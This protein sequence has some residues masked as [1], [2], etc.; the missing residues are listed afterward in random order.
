M[1]KPKSAQKKTQTPSVRSLRVPGEQ[2]TEQRQQS[3]P[4]PSSLDKR[5][6][7]RFFTNLLRV[8]ALFAVIGITLFVF[9][10]RDRVEQF[11]VLGYPGIF[12]I[13]LLANA[14]VLLPAPGVAVIYAM[15]AI[16][17]PFGVGL[18][19]GT[20]GALGELSGYLAGFS[21]QAVVERTDIYNRVRPWVE[22]YGG[23]A[24]LVLSAIPNPFFDIAG[25]AAG[26]AKMPVRTFLLFT[27]VGQLIKMTL[28]ALAG[29]YSIS[30]LNE[31][32]K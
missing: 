11:A 26:I 5:K 24:I 32:I 9:S 15:G 16:F 8:L 20:G 17:N 22:K 13:A 4:A 31:F 6:Q 21:G 18:A 30:M 12:L 1:T 7:N 2:Q 23:W 28:F 3:N 25:I 10:I 29:H 27:W 14:T 19:A